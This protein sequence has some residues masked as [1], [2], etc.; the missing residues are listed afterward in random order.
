MLHKASATCCFFGSTGTLSA[1]SLPAAERPERRAD[2]LIRVLIPSVVALIFIGV[3]I[4]EREEPGYDLQL[5]APQDAAPGASIAFRAFLVDQADAT[6]G[7]IDDADVSVELRR[8]DEVLAHAVAEPSHAE[9]YEGRLL[10]PSDAP[11]QMLLLVASTRQGEETISVRR[12]IRVHPRAIEE[13]LE[14]RGRLQAELQQYG[15]GRLDKRADGQWHLDARVVGGA[16]Q[17]ELP[18]EL[19]IWVGEPAASVALVEANGVFPSHEPQRQEPQSQETQSQ[20]TQCGKLGRE[21]LDEEVASALPESP[22]SSGVLRCP[23][24]V[25]GNEAVAHLVAHRN[26]AVVAQRRV[27]LPLVMG[28]PV[29][30]TNSLVDLG[31]RPSVE[32]RRILDDEVYVLD[33]LHEDH[34]VAALS[35]NSSR[36]ELSVPLTEPGLWRLQL[37]RSTYSEPGGQALIFVGGSIADIVEHPYQQHWLDP[38]ARQEWGP[39]E[40]NTCSPDRIARFML[41]AGEL[42]VAQLPDATSSAM[43]DQRGETGQRGVRR[44]IAAVVIFVAGLVVAF[45]VVRRGRQGMRT[46]SAV[47][48]EAHAEVGE[49]TDADQAESKAQAAGWSVYG[50]ALFVVAVFAVVSAMVLARS[51]L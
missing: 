37:R 46:A 19:L 11:H 50:S 31:S 36:F 39:C 8:R 32:V 5:T 29:L 41:A 13:P 35:G 10:I 12:E 9:G 48:K 40:D 47:M 33:L 2:W 24:V 44:Q 49:T 27:R 23:L 17:P 20:E 6:F 22:A 18:C 38:A 16:C 25:R 4:G 28:S 26:Q 34:W 3:L 14:L 7:L 42:E 45:V 30:E 21:F 43:Q 51:C 15:L 1:L